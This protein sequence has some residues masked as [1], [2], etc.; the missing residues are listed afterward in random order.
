ME[1]RQQHGDAGGGGALS[2]MWGLRPCPAAGRPGEA[3]DEWSVGLDPDRTAPGRARRALD[4]LSPHL[5]RE[6]MENA[7]LLVTE[8]VTNS[9]LHCGG[10]P[11]SITVETHLFP[12]QVVIC[13]GDQGA[14]FEPAAL[15]GSR[16]G[17]PGGR[18]LELVVLLADYLGID[19]RSPFR[20]WFALCR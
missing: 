17:V 5:G 15:L 14:G 1:V 6:D 11:G 4:P 20:V 13:V 10:G 7:R 12:D 18:G 9:V 2:G 3:L 8:L 16:P 19:R